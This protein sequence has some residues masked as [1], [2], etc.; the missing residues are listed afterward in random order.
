MTEAPPGPDD[1][2]TRP[3]N[4]TLRDVAL[5][6]GVSTATASRVLNAPDRVSKTTRNRVTDAVRALAYSPNFAA[7]AMAARRTNTIGAI[8]PTMENAIFA[9][10]LQAFQTALR[11]E[12]FT[13]LVAASAYDPA[14]ESAQIATLIA[15][16]ADGL[17]LIGHERDPDLYRFLDAR[18]VPAL[19]TW[20][21]DPT[22]T[23]PSVGF[24]N[25]AAMRDLAREVLARGHIRLA[26]I[27]AP[28]SGNDRARDRLHGIRDA[29]SEAGLPPDLPVEI[30]P[31][32]IDEGARAFAT[33]MAADP[34][35]TA[36]LSGND[37]LAVGAMRQARA[38]GLDV[39][40]DVSITGF[41]DLELARVTTPELTTIHVPHRQ[42]GRVAA[43]TLVAM[44]RDGTTPASI[45]L[46]AD[47]RLRG[48]LGP[49]PA[50]PR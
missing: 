18:N 42:M 16:G 38:M 34:S 22:E 37:V 19:V 17:L 21:Y 20:A 1:A 43:E 45:S 28:T 41:D 48:S 26:A 35:P 49:P 3:A 5:H 10:G 14:E 50:D 4:P 44:V 8:I 40:R 27:S 9:R 33:L 2:R 13:L 15:R 7:R 6:A 24:D 30:V 31:Y 39:P 25:R 11:A 36:I 46:P 32:G 23:R 12:G 47:L 29:L